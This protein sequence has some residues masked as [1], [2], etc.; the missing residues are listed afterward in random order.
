MW[1]C[2]WTASDCGSVAGSSSFDA[3]SSVA[4]LMPHALLLLNQSS[5]ITRQYAARGERT[6]NSSCTGPCVSLS[7]MLRI[8]GGAESRL[9]SP[10]PLPSDR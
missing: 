7:R 6:V 3:L 4:L 2:W 9:A 1:N 5:A 8:G 10:L